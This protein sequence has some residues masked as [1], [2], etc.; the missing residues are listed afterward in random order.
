M[1]IISSWWLHLLLRWHHH[2]V[3]LLLLL[4]RVDKLHLLWLSA[5]WLHID[6]R[7]AHWL[8]LGLLLEE[9]LLLWLLSLCRN[10]YSVLLVLLLWNLLDELYWYMLDLWHR[11]NLLILR[12]ISWLTYDLLIGSPWRRLYVCDL[13]MVHRHLLSLLHRHEHGL[14]MVHRLWEIL[15][16]VQ[17]SRH[18]ILSGLTWQLDHNILMIGLQIVVLG[19]VC[20]SD[21]AFF[22]L[23]RGNRRIAQV[24]LLHC[25]L[26]WKP[27]LPRF[28][29]EVFLLSPQLRVDVV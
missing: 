22:H 12:V 28:I 7:L 15:G 8:L 1:Q 14:A 26:I 18:H 16:T 24:I 11:L 5:R 4:L 27:L 6:Y 17:I 29:L 21:F 13:L 2:H 20:L 3:L 25:F 23:V 10:N 19:E 9:D